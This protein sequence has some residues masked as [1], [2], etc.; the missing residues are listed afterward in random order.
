MKILCFTRIILAATLVSL[1]IAEEIPINSLQNS[2]LGNWWFLGPLQKGTDNFD[3]VGKI[4][5]DPLNY[6]NKNLDNPF[7]DNIVNVSS[8]LKYGFQPIYQI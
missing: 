2:A 5:K 6:F 8:D 3:F 4:E 7:L 1:T